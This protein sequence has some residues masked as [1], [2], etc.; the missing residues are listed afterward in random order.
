[1]A[2][3]FFSRN[4]ASGT[5][6][7]AIWIASNS[8][9]VTR[10]SAVCMSVV[11]SSSGVVSRVL[12][13]QPEFQVPLLRAARWLGSVDDC[14][15]DTVVLDEVVGINRPLM[16]LRRCSLHVASSR[17]RPRIDCRAR[18]VLMPRYP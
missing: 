18:V 10:A 11:H 13:L 8:A 16:N 7:R 6:P 1:M 2:Q 3:S 17:G 12:H 14:T 15:L 4:S 9:G 5:R